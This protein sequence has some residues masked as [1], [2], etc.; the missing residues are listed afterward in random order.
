MTST[1]KTEK[2]GKETR[3]GGEK[4]YRAI[5]CDDEE[6]VR[7]GLKKHFDWSGHKIEIVGIFEDG[8]PAFEYMKTHEVDIIITD[9]RMIHMDG[10]TLAQ[11]ASVLYPEVKVLFISGYADVEYLKEAL[12][13]D[14]VDYILKSIDLNELEKS[15][16]L[17]RVRLLE[18]LV[19]EH[20]DQE[21]SLEQ[22]VHFL[23]LPLDSST[24]YVILVMRIRHR[25]RRKILDGTA[26]G[27]W[28]GR[29]G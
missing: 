15:M 19:R 14:A 17:L 22:R 8:I 27:H 6:T 9:V 12:K 25:S 10:I 7:N 23:N 28:S 18:E 24:R 11:K 29:D 16:P 21:E 5:I 2:I 1:E 4:M 26:F 13:I 20:S 3:Y